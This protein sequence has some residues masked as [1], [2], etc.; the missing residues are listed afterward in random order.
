MSYMKSALLLVLLFV[1][2]LHSSLGK[3]LVGDRVLVILDNLNDKQSYSKLW[4]SLSDRGFA[5]TFKSTKDSTLSLFEYDER[6]AD[7]LIVFTPKSKKF[8]GSVNVAS[9]VDFI[10][11]GGNLLLATNSNMADQTRE[12]CYEFGIEFDETDTSVID[13]FNYN[14]LSKSAS[15]RHDEIMADN[16]APINAIFPE[17]VRKGP[18]VLYQGVAHKVFRNSPMLIKLLSGNAVTFSGE[19]GSKG[20]IQP[21]VS[22]DEVG[23]VSALQARNNA[24]IVISG[25]TEL[26]SDSFAEAAIQ[27]AVD[28]G[29]SSSAKYEK[30]GNEAFVNE[31]T[32]W[33]FHEK[34]V[35]EVERTHHHKFGEKKQ[36]DRYTIKDKLSYSIAV[37]EWTG[38]NWVPFRAN[39]IQFEAV[40]LDPW[41]RLTLLPD[42][43][44]SSAKAKTS[45]TYS[46]E[47][48]LPDK[49]GVYTFKVDYKRQGF[50]YLLASELVSIVQFRHNE[51]P[52]FLS[53]A[54]VYY[55]GAF[56][57][58]AAVVVFSAIWL[59]HKENVKKAKKTE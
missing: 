26:F 19:I 28:T 38:T 14:S 32:K 17:S 9:I 33:A 36:R 7:H 42:N 43:S 11:R 29:S 12:L 1:I 51:Y 35:I 4:N 25:S 30:S 55:A 18:P 56:S 39:D 45:Q 49:W 37:K 58:M 3:S 40:M 23:L 47:F 16:I 41:I 24:R 34:G 52:R 6:Q 5:L 44:T 15:Q 59:S 31:L 27:R 2:G 46:S 10:N 53:F 48:Q 13:H 22:G 50:T 54:Y 8:G 21:F 20:G 57:Q